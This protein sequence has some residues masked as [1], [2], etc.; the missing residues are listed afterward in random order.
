MTYQID[1]INLAINKKQITPTLIELDLEFINT[2]CHYYLNREFPEPRPPI[3][4]DLDHALSLTIKDLSLPVLLAHV[5]KQQGLVR[6]E[7]SE[8]NNYVIIDGNHRLLAARRLN[9]PLKAYVLIEN[10]LVAYEIEEG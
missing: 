10:M 7:D 4:F 2:Y 6:L 9:Q 5:G 3:H 8:E 1:S